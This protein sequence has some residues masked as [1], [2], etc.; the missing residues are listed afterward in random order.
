ME[1]LSNFIFARSV[2]T[3]QL[4]KRLMKNTTN[5][6]EARDCCNGDSQTLVN[7]RFAMH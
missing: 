4:N 3:T 6:T 7:Y 2:K 5:T 1:C